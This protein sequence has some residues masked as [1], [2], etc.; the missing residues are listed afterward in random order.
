MESGYAVLVEFWDGNAYRLDHDDIIVY[1]TE[2]EANAVA[3]EMKWNSTWG[4]VT[5]VEV[6]IKTKSA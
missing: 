1:P 6:G 2:A 5:V 4:K 3:E